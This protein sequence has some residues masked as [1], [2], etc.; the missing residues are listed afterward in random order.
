MAK[1]LFYPPKIVAGQKKKKMVPKKNEKNT[2]ASWCICPR[3]EG[4]ELEVSRS[5]SQ[6]GQ[7]SKYLDSLTL[8]FLVNETLSRPYVPSLLFHHIN[9]KP[10]FCF[11][12]SL[13]FFF[14]PGYFSGSKL[15]FRAFLQWRRL[16]FRQ[17]CPFRNLA[18]LGPLIGWLPPGA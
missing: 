4:K 16:M 9:L 8:S 11:L 5:N 2:K 18:G 17:E 6:Q 12:L 15:S 10:P 7:L 13:V 1:I 14:F 3:S